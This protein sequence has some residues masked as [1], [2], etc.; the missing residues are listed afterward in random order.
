M[1]NIL[2]AIVALGS[3]ATLVLWLFK[4]YWSADAETRKLKNRLRIV[5]KAMQEAIIDN[6]SDDWSLFNT[7]RLQLLEKLSNIRK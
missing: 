5:R 4:R 3:I 2:L 6:R 7:E 1:T